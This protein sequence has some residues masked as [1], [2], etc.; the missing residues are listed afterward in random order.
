MELS[1][2]PPELSGVR[3]NADAI[4]VLGDHVELMFRRKLEQKVYQSRN[5]HN[6]LTTTTTAIDTMQ[7]SDR[8]C[9]II[10]VKNDNQEMKKDRK[11]KK[12]ESK[13]DKHKDVKR[14]KKKKHEPKQLK[15]IV[16]DV[17]RR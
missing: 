15:C 4:P 10:A 6:L 16:T 9:S 14:N 5:H 8:L 1:Q 12:K 7:S 13:H 3:I 17:V 11:K 2:L